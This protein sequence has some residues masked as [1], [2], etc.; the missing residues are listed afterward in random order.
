MYFIPA[1]LPLRAHFQLPRKYVPVSW[2]QP[3]NPHSPVL[4]EMHYGSFQQV[5]AFV[6]FFGLESRKGLMAYIRVLPLFD[7]SSIKM[8]TLFLKSSGLLISTVVG[9]FL[10]RLTVINSVCNPAISVSNRWMVSAITVPLS[11]MPARI[12]DVSPKLF[13]RISKAIRFNF[14][15]ATSGLKI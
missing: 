14:F 6:F 3:I 13:S 1:R 12:K 11:R 5:P 9:F 2:L 15:A 4:P 8:T 7:T 10:S